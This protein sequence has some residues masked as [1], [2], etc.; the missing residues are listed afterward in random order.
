M[1]SSR[2]SGS[3]LRQPG[4]H[5]RRKR[6]LF[7]S[8]RVLGVESGPNASLDAFDGE[9]LIFEILVAEHEAAA[10]KF[11]DGRFSA[12]FVPEGAGGRFRHLPLGQTVTARQL[13]TDFVELQDPAPRRALDALSAH[14][15]CPHSK[16]GLAKLAEDYQAEIADK[17]VTLL[18]L[19]D[20]FPAVDLPLDQFVE[21]SAAIAP[22]FYSIASS[23]LV[24]PDTAAL[25]VGTMAAPAW[26]GLGEHQGFA[27][28]YMRD[29]KP[30]DQVF[31]YLRR[32]NPPFAPPE[33]ATVP[34]ILIGPGTG[35]APLRGFIEERAAQK[36][37]GK[38]VATSLLFSGCRHPDHDWFC[39]EEV[40]AWEKKGIIEL[41]LALSAVDGH[42]WT[43]VQ[44]AIWAETMVPAT[45]KKRVL[46]IDL[47]QM[48]QA[49]RSSTAC[50]RR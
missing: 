41:H 6:A 35:F 12:Q 28:S 2:D 8:L 26:S 7:H 22:R 17:R 30:G 20:R 46:M 11:D 23:P 47:Q 49:G 38:R 4:D 42:P 18:D 14:T 24:S 34:M 39:R 44:D 9:N 45:I 10:P 32:P 1:G 43:F 50:L 25:I 5:F 37:A 29:L 19:L 33:D 27:S 40:E 13:L 48:S 31:G 16:A 3:I 21:L 15:G 36:V